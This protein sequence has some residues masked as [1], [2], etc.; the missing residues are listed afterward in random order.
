M[1]SSALPALLI[2]AVTFTLDMAWARYTVA[3]VA[4]RIA[5]ASA[6]AAGIT[7]L[8]GICAISYVENHWMLIPAVLGASVGTTV[9]MLRNGNE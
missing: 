2:F 8:S 9:G 7:A 3:L 4:R 1:L 6:Y 5:A